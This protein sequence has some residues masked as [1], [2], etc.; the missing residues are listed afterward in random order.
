MP[1]SGRGKVL[2]VSRQ[3]LVFERVH[4]L[5]IQALRVPVDNLE[6][7]LVASLPVQLRQIRLGCTLQNSGSVTVDPVEAQEQLF[8]QGDRRLDSHKTI[9]LPHR[10]EPRPALRVRQAMKPATPVCRTERVKLPLL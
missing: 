3:P 5:S 2:R 1:S 9:V 4:R 8:G 6:V 10:G 7:T